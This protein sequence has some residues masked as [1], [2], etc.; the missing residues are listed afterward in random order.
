MTRILSEVLRAEEP[1]FGLT[2][3]RLEQAAGR[4]SADVRLTSEV[5]AGVANKLRALN[6]DPKDTTAEELYRALEERLKTD[7]HFVREALGLADD[8]ASAEV[9]AAVQRYV[10]NLDT[11]PRAFALKNSTVRRMLKK[12]PPKKTMKQLGY[13]SLDSM[14]K[15][16]TPAVLYTAAFLCEAYAWRKKLFDQFSQLQPKDFETRKVEIVVPSS[17]R[18][19]ELAAKS[20]QA[21]KHTIAAHKELG[22]IVLLPQA[23]DMPG[24]ALINLTMVTTA[25]NDIASTASFLKLQQVK[26]DFGARVRYVA[27]HEPMTNAALADQPVPWRVIHQYYARFKQAYNAAIFE[28]HVQPEDLNWQWPE[29]MLARLHEA[30]EFWLDTQYTVL[31][32]DQQIVSLNIHDVAVN[33]CNRLPFAKRITSF[34]QQHLWQ[35]LMVRYLS[36]ENIEHAITGQLQQEFVTIDDQPSADQWS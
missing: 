36:H 27:E 13:R 29:H 16:E 2:L 14:L 22:T 35:E 19:S 15:H 24:F 30:L 1:R 21:R 3:Q 25:L 5:L 9:L 7:E 32:R 18:W 4:P 10:S 12:V 17:K 34:A 31:L 20:S 23:V 26:P 11:L 28:P 6:L 8:A 33:Y